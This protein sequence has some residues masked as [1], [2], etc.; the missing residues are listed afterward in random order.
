MS[1]LLEIFG[2][3]ITFDTADLIWH[4]LD[5]C[6]Q[7][8]KA[9]CDLPQYHQLDKVIELVRDMKL[10]AAQQQLRLYLFENPSCTH[11]RMAAAALCLHN[12]QLQRGNRGAKL[13]LSAPA[14]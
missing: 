14:D 6:R 9:D 12:N 4:W 10:D 2:R 7:Q 5:I 1:R 8:T 11:G 13:R 3:A